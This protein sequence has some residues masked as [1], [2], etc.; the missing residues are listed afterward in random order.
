MSTP[1]F[2]VSTGKEKKKK[3]LFFDAAY[4]SKKKR[5]PFL[6]YGTHFKYQYP[7]LE[8]QSFGDL[9]QKII[10]KLSEIVQFKEEIIACIPK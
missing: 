2:P 8:Q 5:E 6:K 4:V 3:N 7:E 9:F 1:L 10:T